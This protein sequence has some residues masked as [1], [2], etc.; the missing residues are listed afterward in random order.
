MKKFLSTM[1]IIVVFSMVLF[2]CDK[3]PRLDTK[4]F[5]TYTID[6]YFDDST[7]TLSAYQTVKYTNRTPNVLNNVD[8]HLYPNAFSKDAQNK[9]VSLVNIPKAYPNGISYG[10]INITLLKVN[11]KTSPINITGSDNNILSVKLNKDLYPDESATIN[12]EYQVTLPNVNHRFGYGGNT[13]NFGNFYPIACVY[14]NGFMTKPY[15]SNGDPFYSD[16]ANYNVKLTFDK[17]FKIASTGEVKLKTKDNLSC[18]E[19]K[20]STVRDFA[21]VLS[22][23]FQTISTTI[24][25]TKITYYY[26]EDE[27]SASNLKIAKDA[28][29]TFNELFGKYPYKT[30][31]IVKTNFLHGGMEYP[32][33]V[34]VSDDIV[35]N[36]EYQNVIVHEIAHQWWY[37]L[38]GS[39]AYDNAW[40][41]EG[42]TE[43]STLM[44]YQQ[45]P[46]Y[47]V[48]FKER[49][50][51]VMASYMLFV[52]V[53]ESVNG[54]LDTSMNRPLDK[55][56]SEMEYVYLTYVKGT[57]MFDEIRSVMGDKKFKKAL[58]YYFNNNCYGIAYPEDL[59]YAF[60]K[61]TSKNMESFIN[62]WLSGKVVLKK[63][64]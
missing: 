2:G 38:V 60:N 15:N 20:I 17:D 4:N 49:I 40:Q 42:L 48:D 3:V 27:Y 19:I 36:L 7:K 53:F 21:F 50:Q 30:L 8:F 22:K 43:Y 39:N 34:Y 46:Q 12:M 9:P 33:L 32:T 5:N 18:A 13:Y 28:I 44:F 14:N 11:N 26:Y 55:Y 6:A 54:S 41:D 57:L 25:N 10:G 47:G 23:K 35:N 1:F 59:I 58:Q 62:S 29:K 56:D 31:S 16:M 51:S 63:A 24:N 64:S 52:D 61:K 45:N 37:N